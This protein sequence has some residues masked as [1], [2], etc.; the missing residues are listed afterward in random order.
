MIESGLKFTIK[1]LVLDAQ[2]M[3]HIKHLALRLDL[4]GYVHQRSQ[5]RLEGVLVGDTENMDL[6]LKEIQRVFVGSI[7]SLETEA[8][9]VQATQPIFEIRETDGPSTD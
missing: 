9:V 8:V 5:G 3:T 1:G 7:L 6:L 4:L 2:I